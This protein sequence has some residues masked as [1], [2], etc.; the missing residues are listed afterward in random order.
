MRTYFGMARIKELTR[1]I[2]INFRPQQRLLSEVLKIMILKMNMM[3][4]VFG[5]ITLKPQRLITIT[6]LPQLPQ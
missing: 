4:M 1:T 2:K 5:M 6:Q 3:I